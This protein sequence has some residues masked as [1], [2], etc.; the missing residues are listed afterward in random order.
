VINNFDLGQSK[1]EILCLLVLTIYWIEHECDCL[2]GAALALA[3]LW[4]IFPILMLGYL[5]TRRKY[6][7]LMWAVGWLAAGTLL[8]IKF[9]GWTQCMNFL[10]G[11]QS[12]DHQ[13]LLLNQN[14]LCM[15]AVILRNT[16]SHMLAI[17]AVAVTL[18]L[19]MDASFGEER[20]WRI[21]ALWVATAVLILPLSWTYDMVILLIP[22]AS[23][24]SAPA[25]PGALALLWLSYLTASAQTW[26]YLF[27]CL[28]LGARL[29]SFLYPISVHAQ[30]LAPLGC[31]FA[32]LL[33]A[34]D[35][36]NLKL[37]GEAVGTPYLTV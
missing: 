6:R 34:R 11:L 35:S 23:L 25:P 16:G 24:A 19:T 31:Y 36:A 32:A 15:T 18:G 29:T 1:I 7:T 8:T 10:F 3:S 33:F 5:A 4:R 13:G 37:P 17:A 9:V 28:M 30:W 27:G 2:A 21:F 14:N 22:F 12:F 26:L 20:D